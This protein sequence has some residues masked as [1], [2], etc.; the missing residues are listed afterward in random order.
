M[1]EADHRCAI[2]TCRVVAPLNIE[3]IDDWARVQKHEFDNLIVLCA[4]CH[5][6]K[7]D[8]TNARHLDRKALR[9]YKANLGLLNARYGDFERRVIELFASN[10]GARVIKLTGGS[11]INRIQLMHL[12][13]DGMLSRPHLAEPSL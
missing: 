6:L 2:P 9:Q 10:P 12:L 1:L 11:D 13:R 3:H 5:G 8:K 4:N 7:K